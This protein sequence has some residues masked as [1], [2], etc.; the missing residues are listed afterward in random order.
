MTLTHRYAKTKGDP[1]VANPHFMSADLFDRFRS[2]IEPLGDTLGP[3]ILQFGY[4]N[5][6]HLRGQA[7]LLDRLS[8]FL[9]EISSGPLCGIE[10]RNPKWLDSRHFEF[11]HRHDLIPVLLEGYWMPPIWETHREHREILHEADTVVIRLHGPDREGMQ[12]ETGKQWDTIVVRWDEDLRHVVG[13]VGELLDAGVTVYLNVNN[14]YEG[15]A[16]LTIERIQAML[17]FVDS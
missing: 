10:I 7:E 6:R 5:Q 16:T 12:R 17:G 8:G 1:L 13:M 9:E 14:H 3:V 4:L 11:I 15:S 2:L